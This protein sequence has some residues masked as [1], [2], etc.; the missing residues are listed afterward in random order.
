MIK[1]ESILS[2]H[3]FAASLFVIINY[4][5]CFYGCLSLQMTKRQVAIH[6]PITFLWG[7]FLGILTWY[8]GFDYI[9]LW[10]MLFEAGYMF[11][12]IYLF[13]EGSFWYNNVCLII[14]AWL[15]NAMNIFTFSLIDPNMVQAFYYEVNG[16]LEIDVWR[17]LLMAGSNVIFFLPAKNIVRKIFK[18]DG[19]W[20]WFYRLFFVVF[21][22]H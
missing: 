8:A 11:V 14:S 13:A 20:E 3:L 7:Y 16:Y 2:M 10:I 15:V 5:C 12:T 17:M 18:K 19:S 1:T 4:L 22:L 9:Y 21:I 6:I